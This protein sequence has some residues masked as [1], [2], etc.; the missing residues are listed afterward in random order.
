MSEK[1]RVHEVAHELGIDAKEVITS[2]S[3][4]G[5]VLKSASSSMSME[6][7]E[8]IANY[9]INGVPAQIKMDK[10]DTEKEIP[11]EENM[12][13]QV[14]DLAT[15]A[16]SISTKVEQVEVACQALDI[17]AEKGLTEIQQVEIRKYFLKQFREKI[18]EERDKLKV[19][20]ETFEAYKKTEMSKLKEKLLDK[21]LQHGQEL[22]AL[23][24]KTLTTLKDDFLKDIAKEYEQI[25]SKLDEVVQK[26]S[27][28]IHWQEELDQDKK[29]FLSDK[30]HFN[31]QKQKL[32]EEYKKELEQQ[33]EINIIQLEEEKSNKL[34]EVNQKIESLYREKQNSL[35][36]KET[37]LLQ[38]EST[39][40]IKE[41]ELLQ[42]EA[43]LKEKEALLYG[44]AK[45]RVSQEINVLE[46]K[47]EYTEREINKL[48]E[49]YF[50]LKTELSDY[51]KYEDRDLPRELT[52]KND[53]IRLLAQKLDELRKQK[54]S[55]ETQKELDF[56]GF[57]EKIRLLHDENQK[58]RIEIEKIEQL[59][60]ENT[61][62]SE[63]LKEISFLKSEN[64]I[65]QNRLDSMNQ[66]FTQSKE[67]ELRVED[68][69]REPYLKRELQEQVNVSNE[70]KWLDSI[71][72]NMKQYG[73]TY[74]KRLLYAFHTALKSAEYSPL[75]V[76]AGVSGTGKSELPK[77]YS[78]FGGFNFLA[79]AV[80]PTWDSPESML[81]YYNTIE[82]K[83]D[84]SNI[85]KFLLQT[86]Q[87]KDN[88]QY[89]FKESMNMILLDE[90]NLAH[91]EL[92]FAEFLSKFELR[93]GSKGV[94]LD[95][96]LG[97]GMNYPL[98]LD[99]NVLWI[100]TMN[101]DETTKALS[102]KVLDRSFAINFP[103]PDKLASRGIL[104]TLDEIKKFEYLHR[105]TWEK[106]IQKST[107]FTDDNR[108]ILNKFKN[109]SNKLNENLAPT[110]R[111]IGHRV[112][113]SMEFYIQNHPLVI[114]SKDDNELEKNVKLAFEEQLV[115]KIMP[116]LRGIE[117]HG[118]EKEVLQDIKSM[119]VQEDFKIVEDF[120]LSMDNPYGQFIWNSANY[121]KE[122]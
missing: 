34:Q 54:N 74:P 64:Q 39:L 61:I 70:I 78:H 25:T 105:D 71:E 41:N 94:N 107:I 59:K 75:S 4:I 16:K 46:D 44:Q 7:A 45:E 57:E 77:L 103:R 23:K 49:E 48:K 90:M 117:I 68:I 79:E 91:I 114:Q 1:V 93:R 65:L 33:K 40:K 118:K 15:F 5:I 119:L 62:L 47:Q 3:K 2:A 37:E 63:K 82:N 12:N 87:G 10:E 99:R 89:G 60:S 32:Y 66:L 96:K 69:K 19:D 26:E 21:E 104:R 115:Q 42:N 84:S 95:I 55:I 72:A 51:E 92:Y 22:E 30:E 121:L 101:E 81:G 6:E 97:A 98:P 20:K 108:E 116:K 88:A 111:A 76:L 11:M 38:K 18:I 43:V 106:W 112:W 29:M 110:G 122:D 100:G 9:I 31:A 85:L 36:Q 14:V 50:D 73:V 53:E 17:N 120:E 67:K 58:F 109:I 56:S 13:N 52:E 83:F 24:I 80:Q 8:K 86:S 35:D 27:K 102:D 28:L 113:Q